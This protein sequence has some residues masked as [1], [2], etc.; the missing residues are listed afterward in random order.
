M[1]A[2]DGT[3]QAIGPAYAQVLRSSRDGSY[4]DVF[5]ARAVFR[6]EAPGRPTLDKSPAADRSTQARIS[7]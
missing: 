1:Y 4:G 7:P 6:D 2:A 3:A 5:V